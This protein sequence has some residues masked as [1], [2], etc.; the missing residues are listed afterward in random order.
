MKNIKEIINNRLLDLTKEAQELSNYR[1]E[2]VN[3][4]KET[5]QRLSQI[6]AVINELKV[7]LDC[8]EVDQKDLAGSFLQNQ[9]YL[10]L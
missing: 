2:L 6:V 5:D 8:C 7:L 9:V 4:I 1:I 10:E 3:N